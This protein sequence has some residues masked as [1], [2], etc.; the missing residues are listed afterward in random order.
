VLAHVDLQAVDYKGQGSNEAVTCD[1]QG[2]HLHLG[3]RAVAAG[4]A[5]VP[6][7]PMV[8][9]FLASALYT[10]VNIHL[11]EVTD[12]DEDVFHELV[13]GYLLDQR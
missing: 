12:T 10:A 3:H 2:I 9:L 5:R 11:A 7:D 4:L 8:V 13:A 1:R 6:P